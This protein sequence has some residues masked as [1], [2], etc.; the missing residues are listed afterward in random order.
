[1]CLKG[2]LIDKANNACAFFDCCQV[3]AGDAQWI[4]IIL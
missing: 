3:G 2:K 1:M 4:V